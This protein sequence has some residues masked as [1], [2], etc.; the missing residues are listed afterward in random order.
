MAG[1]VPGNLAYRVNVRVQNIQYAAEQQPP[2]HLGVG[3]H[4]GAVSPAG[5]RLAPTFVG[6]ALLGPLVQYR[7]DKTLL[8]FWPIFARLEGGASPYRRSPYCNVDLQHSN[9]RAYTFGRHSPNRFMPGAEGPLLGQYTQRPSG[10]ELS[11]T[12]VAIAAT[13]VS[14]ANDP[15]CL[16]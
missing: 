11:T 1:L 10:W 9:T 6:P 8:L 3:A 12:A 13:F 15:R 14:L 7:C 4:L 16:A 2:P 5:Q